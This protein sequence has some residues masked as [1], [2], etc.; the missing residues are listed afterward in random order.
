M[1][2]PRRPPGPPGCP[3]RRQ[4]EPI[5]MV[6]GGFLFSVTLL[7]EFLDKRT[8]IAAGDQVTRA[9]IFGASCTSMQILPS[10]SRTRKV[11]S[12][13]IAFLH[14]SLF[15]TLFGPLI[16]EIKPTRN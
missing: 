6:C 5:P 1:I 3:G 11:F 10:E 7:K 9:E 14:S 4:S 12:S 15:R 16:N 2:S 13:V 8:L